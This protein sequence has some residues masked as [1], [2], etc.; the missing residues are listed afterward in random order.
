[1]LV[2]FF[3][4]LKLGIPFI[5][6]VG[7][8]FEKTSSPTVSNNKKFLAIP[9]VNDLPKATKERSLKVS[10]SSSPNTTV[11]I[12]V[13]GDAYDKTQTSPD[14]SFIFEVKL[15]IGDNIIKARTVDGDNEGE[16]SRSQ[17]V[18]YK[19][20]PPSL[21][22]D[23]PSDGSTTNNETIAISGKT[24]EGVTVTVNDFWAVI[25]PDNTYSYALKLNQGDNQIK[26]SAVD[27]AG[28]KT[29]KNIKVT[30]SP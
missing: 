8:L 18:T 1:M 16:F 19:N 5:V 28:N 3:L 25:N 10:G 20:S 26:V 9:S 13:S 12:F 15:S 7:N 17:T 6:T 30:Y 21:T 29:E 23:N 4:I 2:V 24:D 14:G 22:I 11:E 27:E